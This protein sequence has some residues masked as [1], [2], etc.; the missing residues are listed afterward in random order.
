[1]NVSLLWTQVAP[2]SWLSLNLVM[3]FTISC[4]IYWDGVQGMKWRESFGKWS[5]TRS[6]NDIA[7]ILKHPLS[8]IQ[9][10][11][12]IYWIIYITGLWDLFIYWLFLLDVWVIVIPGE[13]WKIDWFST[14]WKHENGEDIIVCNLMIFFWLLLLE[15]A[16]HFA[17]L[18]LGSEVLWFGH[19]SSWRY[20]WQSDNWKCWSH[21]EVCWDLN[22]LL[23]QCIGGMVL[24]LTTESVGTMSLWFL[25]YSIHWDY[26]NILYRYNVAVKC[27]TITPGWFPLSDPV[28]F[29][30]CVHELCNC[31]M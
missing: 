5:R 30:V 3:H 24:C 7:M 25:C 26:F 21:L 2:S 1:M 10:Y 12:I 18:G 15:N 16:A 11:W 29:D 8:E 28:L 4:R 17:F 31:F 13:L 20:W 19:P 22:P 27:A 23:D 14:F 6:V 9:I